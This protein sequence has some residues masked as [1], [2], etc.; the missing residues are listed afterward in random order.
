MPNVH[1]ARQLE[2]VLRR[3]QEFEAA[4]TALEVKQL[5]ERWQAEDRAAEAAETLIAK[6]YAR[7]AQENIELRR[8]LEHNTQQLL[9]ICDHL[10]SSVERLEAQQLRFCG[11]YEHGKKYQANSLV[12]RKGGLWIAKVDNDLEPGGNAAWQLVTRP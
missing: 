6:T 1:P 8:R 12:V 3:R 10:I 11:I 9:K 2:V 7:L 5:L 4:A